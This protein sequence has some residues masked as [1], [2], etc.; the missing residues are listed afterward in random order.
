MV[1][2]FV[3]WA[4][5]VATGAEA[6]RVGD[7]SGWPVDAAVPSDVDSE[8]M[9]WA[10]YKAA[11]AKRYVDRADEGARRLAFEENVRVIAEL[12]AKNDAGEHSFRCGVN[13]FSDLSHDELRSRYL[14]SGPAMAEAGEWHRALP[15]ANLTAAPPASVDW[16]SKGAVGPVKNQGAC[17]PHPITA[18][19]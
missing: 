18:E 3:A 11:F 17:G 5:M 13:H 4:L 14:T 6:V 16:K 19:H 2:A 12:N 10:A 9:S 1:S 15:I 7:A 8:T